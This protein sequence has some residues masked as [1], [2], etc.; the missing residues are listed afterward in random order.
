MSVDYGSAFIGIRTDDGQSF[1]YRCDYDNE[2][3]PILQLPDNWKDLFEDV[4]TRENMLSS[5]FD[6]SFDGIK[7]LKAAANAFNAPRHGVHSKREYQEFMKKVKIIDSSDI[8]FIALGVAHGGHGFYSHDWIVLDMRNEQAQEK[9]WKV[10]YGPDTGPDMSCIDEA[11]RR[12]GT[13]LWISARDKSGEKEAEKERIKQYIINPDLLDLKGKTVVF[14]G[15]TTLYKCDDG[16][17]TSDELADMNWTKHI[18]SWI[19]AHKPEHP[20][21][22]RVTALGGSVRSTISGKTD[23]FVID[24]IDDPPYMKPFFDQKE[25]GKPVM[26]LMYEKFM[27]LLEVAEGK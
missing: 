17:Y 9:S 12:E 26:L 3:V 20:L 16:C 14:G 2:I 13:P 18:E 4:E 19:E 23:Y 24:S 22:K 25:K 8:T 7:N 21:N 27:E 11:I 1:D 5:S 6:G 15:F 10:N